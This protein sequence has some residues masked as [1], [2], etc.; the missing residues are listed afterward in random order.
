VCDFVGY[1]ELC[2]TDRVAWPSSSNSA[3]RQ[4]DRASTR[5]PG[6]TDPV[7]RAIDGSPTVLVSEITA[8]RAGWT[9][10]MVSA[11]LGR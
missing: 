11:R 8:W 9:D 5:F 6:A 10:P 7:R 1:R 4:P 2:D 3:V